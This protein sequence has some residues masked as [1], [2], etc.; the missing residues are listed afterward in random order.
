MQENFIFTNMVLNLGEKDSNYS[1]PLYQ[2]DFH[3]ILQ[4]P[5]V[6]ISWATICFLPN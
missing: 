6:T 2:L 3:L 4:L 1:N 5:S